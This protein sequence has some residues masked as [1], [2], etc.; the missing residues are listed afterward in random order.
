QF[1][2][3]FRTSRHISHGRPLCTD[4][5][6]LVFLLS[7]TLVSLLSLTLV[8][9][10]SAQLCLPKSITHR[11][12]RMNPCVDI[13]N[14]RSARRVKCLYDFILSTQGLNPGARAKDSAVLSA[15]STVFH[16]TNEACALF[17]QSLKILLAVRVR[18]VRL[19]G[20]DR[21]PDREY[22]K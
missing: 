4:A 9:L 5:L 14:L 18:D 19:S 8:S 3:V 6:T 16:L 1:C 17:L 20:H 15:K 13:F 22:G 12:Y 2:C 11:F 21:N 7:L 10:L